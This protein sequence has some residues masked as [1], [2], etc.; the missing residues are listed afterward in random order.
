[1]KAS[2]PTH[3]QAIQR[4]RDIVKRIDATTAH[5]SRRDALELVMG[6]IPLK[7]IED[8]LPA[9]CGAAALTVTTEEEK[10]WLKTL[11]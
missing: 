5:M 9:I 2:F 7:E 1:V 4:R 8:A 3:L 11:V 10:K 6:L